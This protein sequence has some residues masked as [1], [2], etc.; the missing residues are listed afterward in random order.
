MG[1][2]GDLAF[3][4]DGALYIPEFA[5]D[6]ILRVTPTTSCRAD[7]NGDGQVNF[8]DLLAVLAAWG[9]CSCCPED[10]DAYG[11]VAFDDL[12]AVLSA[13]GPCK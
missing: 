5:K 9:P 11:V 6:R 1:V 4:A 2:G 8:D 7:V 3:G 10:I 13:W 12:L